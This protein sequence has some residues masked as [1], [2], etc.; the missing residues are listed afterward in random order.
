MCKVEGG[1]L[2]KKV[3]GT[4]GE[5]EI[6]RHRYR[7]RHRYRYRYRYRHRYRHRYRYRYRSRGLVSRHFYTYTTGSPL[8]AHSGRS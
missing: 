8:L 7:H 4:G 1:S 3:A 2:Q 6:S 5:A